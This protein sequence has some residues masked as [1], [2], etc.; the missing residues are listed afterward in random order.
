MKTLNGIVK[1]RDIGIGCWEFETTDGAHYEIVGGD[2]ELYQ[3][4]KQATISGKVREDV[5]S[6][7]NIGPI[8]EID[9]VA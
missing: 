5:M 1:F 8:F 3:D 4:G 9:S 7:A 2:A 6:T